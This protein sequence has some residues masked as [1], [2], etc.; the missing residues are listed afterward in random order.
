MLNALILIGPIVLL[1]ALVLAVAYPMRVNLGRNRG[2]KIQLGRY[3]LGVGVVGAVA[4]VAG[5]ALGIAVFCA[6]EDAENLCGLGGVFG[7]GPLLAGLGIA[8]S[9]HYRVRGVRDAP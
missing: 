6:P 5:A 2:E 4:F 1:T 7:L 8:I 9:A 3:T